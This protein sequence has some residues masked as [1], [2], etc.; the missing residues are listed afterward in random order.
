MKNTQ[1]HKRSTLKSRRF[2]VDRQIRMLIARTLKMI[3]KNSLRLIT[4]VIK[5]INMKM[6]MNWVFLSLDEFLT[7]IWNRQNVIYTAVDFQDYIIFIFEA[8]RLTRDIEIL[9]RENDENVVEISTFLINRCLTRIL[10]ENLLLSLI[11]SIIFYFMMRFRHIV[12]QF[13]V[14][15]AIHLLSYY[16]ALTFVI[17]CVVIS[18]ILLKHL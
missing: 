5:I 3:I 9:D 2:A 11:F 13:F 7:G 17:V 15:F 4:S 10:I 14:F 8:Y 12:D 6:L 1:F 18:E 16:I